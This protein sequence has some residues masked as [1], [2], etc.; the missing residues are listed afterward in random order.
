MYGLAGVL[1]YVLGNISNFV[2]WFGVVRLIHSMFYIL[3][4]VI[5]V[6]LFLFG[7][8][9]LIFCLRLILCPHSP[10]PSFGQYFGIYLKESQRLNQINKKKPN[11]V[12]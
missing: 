12:Q 11:F 8:F 10:L 4:V 3:W 1:C 5:N 6:V 9:L 7:F 2:W